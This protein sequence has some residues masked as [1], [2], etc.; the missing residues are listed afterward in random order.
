[1]LCCNADG[2]DKLPLLIIGKFLKP[3]C[4]KNINMDNL[5]VTYRENTKAWMT[6]VLFQE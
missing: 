4:M 5:G 3:R 2:T 6:A 1:M